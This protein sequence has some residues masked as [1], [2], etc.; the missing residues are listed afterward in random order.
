MSKGGCGKEIGN[1]REK[2]ED[3]ERGFESR[4]LVLACMDFDGDEVTVQ[5]GCG[6][7]GGGRASLNGGGGFR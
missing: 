5:Y 4:C 6:G 2:R 1:L 3:E 7:C